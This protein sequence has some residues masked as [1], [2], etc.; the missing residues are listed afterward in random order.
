[1]V[2]VRTAFTVL[3]V[4]LVFAIAACGDDN[5]G[6]VRTVTVDAPAATEEGPSGIGD[7]IL[8]ETRIPDPRKHAG[9]VLD[10]SVIGG[11]AFCPGGRRGEA[12]PVGRSPRRS[13]VVAAA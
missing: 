7:A 8:I 13:S 3:L 1:M 11:S 10:G 12:A 5:G 2:K 6:G 4:V 9:E